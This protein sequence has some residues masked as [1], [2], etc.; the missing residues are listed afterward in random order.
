MIDDPRPLAME[1]LV[2]A[3]ALILLLP[4]LLLIGINLRTKPGNPN[5]PQGSFGLPLIGESVQFIRDNWTGH[6][7]KFVRDRIERYGSTVFSTSLFGEP[8][9]FLCGPAGN[10]FLFSN[11]GKKVVQWWP[12]HVRQL[13]GRSLFFLTGDEARVRRKLMMAGLFNTNSLKKCVPKM[14]EVTRGYFETHWQG[15]VVDRTPF[16][17]PPGSAADQALIYILPGLVADQTLIYIM[18]GP[19]VN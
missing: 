19:A 15:L 5:L 11:E 2:P 7:D 17:I 9:V 1:L 8:M 14:D 16:S 12:A 3:L 6:G 4:A 13:M 10:K 18:P